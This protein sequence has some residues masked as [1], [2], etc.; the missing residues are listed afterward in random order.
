[1]EVLPPAA[2]LLLAPGRGALVVTLADLYQDTAP[3]L[4][5]T[6]AQLGAGAGKQGGLSRGRVLRLQQV[7]LSLSYQL[8][9]HGYCSEEGAAALPGTSAAGNNAAG[10]SRGVAVKGAGGLPP[11]ALPW[12]PAE[13]GAALVELVMRVAAAAPPAAGGGASGGVLPDLNGAFHLDVAV[14][15]GC[16]AVRVEE[17]LKGGVGG[18]LKRRLAPWQERTVPIT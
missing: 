17:G 6:A 15:A 16:Q 18:G 10:S 14:M 7:L 13:R 4:A 1:L 5:A 3:A 11:G 8:L 12:P 9:L 2:R